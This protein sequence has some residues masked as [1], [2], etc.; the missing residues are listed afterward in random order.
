VGG[1]VGVGMDVRGF[2]DIVLKKLIPNNHL[3]SR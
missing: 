3:D 1:W 2:V